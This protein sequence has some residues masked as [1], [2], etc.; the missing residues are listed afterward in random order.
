MDFKEKFVAFVDILGFKSMVEAAERGEGRPTAELLEILSSL[1]RAKD[2]EFY[3]NDGPM[4]C[5][6]SSV[7]QKDLDFEI[8][9][10][11]DCVIISAEMSH[12]GIINLISH[13]WA[14]AFS[15]LRKGVVLRG[16]ITRGSVIH[17]G[18]LILGTGYQKAYQR[19]P[20]CS[21]PS[22]CIDARRLPLFIARSALRD[23]IAGLQAAVGGMQ[24][25]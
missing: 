18:N 24:T 2:K 8:T 21:I 10:I 15:L 9:Q 4:I 16:Y 17:K 11:S 20:M 1:E 19:E 3:V 13:C 14:I 22:H 6:D 25:A 23:L 12:A 5:P 7:V